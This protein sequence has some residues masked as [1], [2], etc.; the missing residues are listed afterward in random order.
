MNESTCIVFI[1]HFS[2]LMKLFSP[3]EQDGG[4]NRE[5]KGA[6]PQITALKNTAEELTPSLEHV[7][8]MLQSRR[9][10][11]WGAPAGPSTSSA[12]LP[13][14]QALRGNEEEEEEEEVRSHSPY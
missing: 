13:P 12:C 11:P 2:R 3:E 6:S 5:T 14:S 9:A 8:R 10:T 1:S 4:Y 7:K